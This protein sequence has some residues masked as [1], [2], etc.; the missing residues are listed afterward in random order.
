MSAANVLEYS[1]VTSLPLDSSPRYPNDRVSFQVNSREGEH[2]RKERL[3]SK[4]L[5]PSLEQ[6]DSVAGIALRML[7]NIVSH[8]DR[9][10]ELSNTLV[11]MDTELMKSR[12]LLSKAFGYRDSLGQG[13]A[14]IVN[15]A[16]WALSNSSADLPSRRQVRVLGEV[17]EKLR[18]GP[19]MRFDSAMKLMDELESEGFDIEPPS[20]DDLL[21]AESMADDNA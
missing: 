5:Y 15:A 21:V 7:D 4:D 2:Q 6:G 8:L 3:G 13:Y 12:I 18:I 20:L 11:D 1:A 16:A 9:A 10:A 19:Y 17:L 14:G